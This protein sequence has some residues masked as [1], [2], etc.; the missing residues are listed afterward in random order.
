M[1]PKDLVKEAQKHVKSITC[2]ELEAMSS[3]DGVI[4]LDVR[5]PSEFDAGHIE[6]AINI[7]RGVVEF[8][9]ADAIPDKEAKIVICCASG[10][11]ASLAGESLQKIGYTNI[12]YLEGGY[13]E[14]CGTK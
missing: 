1:D 11:R 6:G 9:I 13:K 2:E 14:Y 5:E 12:T 8:K 3:S 10:G 4:V 7:P